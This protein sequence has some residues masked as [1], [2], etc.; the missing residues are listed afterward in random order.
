MQVMALAILTM[1]TMMIL[2]IKK[3]L[4]NIFFVIRFAKNK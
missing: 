3:N 2:Q 1:I 4:Q